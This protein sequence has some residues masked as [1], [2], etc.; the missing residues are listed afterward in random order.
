MQIG[1]TC[2][3]SLFCCNTWNL[4]K[5]LLS[6]RFIT[7]VKSHLF[8]DNIFIWTLQLQKDSWAAVYFYLLFFFL[9]PHLL[10]HFF[11][12]S[13]LISRHLNKI[14]KSFNMTSDLETSCWVF[15]ACFLFINSLTAILFFCF[16]QGQ[17]QVCFIACFFVAIWLRYYD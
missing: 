10:C 12:L 7:P 6:F 17:D 1:A 5:R 13:L 16:V 3:H 15:P 11:S 4:K 9:F 2:R 8:L 14:L